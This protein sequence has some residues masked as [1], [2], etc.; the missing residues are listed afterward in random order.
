MTRALVVLLML[1]ACAP[2]APIA[3]RT[4][5][6][7]YTLDAG[8]VQLSDRP[9]RIDFGRTDHSTIPAM[10]KL[11]GRGPTATGDCAGGGQKVD[12]P[13]G[14]TLVFAAG[15]FRGWTSAAGSAGLSC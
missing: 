8:G 9:Q 2:A 3:P 10:T 1:A 6:I 11:V 5:S 14:T 15:E 13:D 12:W 4:T 7:P